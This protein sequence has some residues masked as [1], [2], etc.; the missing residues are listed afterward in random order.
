MRLGINSFKIEGRLKSPAYVA[1]TV[2]AYRARSEGELGDSDVA[3]SERSLARIYSRGFFSGWLH[4]VEHQQLVNARLSSHHGLRI[5]EIV[6]IERDALIVQSVEPIAPGEGLVFLDAES[7][8]EIGASVFH[9]TPMKGDTWMLSFARDFSFSQVEPGMLVY[10]N[11]SPALQAEMERSFSDRNLLKRIPLS[12]SASGTVGQSLVIKA[13]DIDGNSVTVTS[14]TALE[15]A[16]RAPLSEES[17]ELELGALGGSVFVLSKLDVS[18][19]TPCFIH[20]RELK[21]MRRAICAALSQKRRTSAVTALR[22]GD[23]TLTWI[24]ERQSPAPSPSSSSLNVL[25][26]D[27][28]QLDTLSGLPIST[29]YLDFEFGKEYGPAV[30]RVRAMGYR[31]GIATTRIFKPSEQGHLK[32]IQRLKPDEVLVRNLSALEI[33]RTSGLSLIGDFSLN[34]TNSLSAE[35]FAS[36]GLVRLCPSYDLNGEQ[37]EGLLQASDA[38]RFEIT[39]HQYIPAFHMEHCVFAAF[40]SNGSS[41][42]DCGRPCE[43]HRVELRDPKGALHPLKA[44]AEC[45]N[46]MFNGVPQ[47]AAKLIPLLSTMGVTAF[48]IE[49][50][51][52]SPS[53]LRAKIEAY[54][55]VLFDGKEPVV[56]MAQLGLVERYGVTDGQLYNI[57]SYQDRKKDFVSLNDLASSA[58]PGLQQLLRREKHSVPG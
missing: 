20:N 29:V 28:E 53:E 11:A 7:Q 18:L 44:D 17:L 46:T 36:K 48:R 43:R 45:R 3:T 12:L 15:A 14:Q 51:F 49:G 25:I 50:L 32:V 4:G 31:V 37:L 21:E 34:V 52:E 13:T 6:R 8:K 42:R 35:W 57:R 40:L 22:S 27:F 55:S 47:S 39:V 24:T 33:L 58:D 19:G 10:V 16:R 41:Y 30:E 38:S 23:E 26:R 54:A 56:A 2:R 9:S 5:G 1:S